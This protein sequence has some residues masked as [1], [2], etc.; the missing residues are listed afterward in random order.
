VRGIDA[1]RRD[2]TPFV[3]EAQMHLLEMLAREEQPEAALPAAISFLQ[4]RLR[5]LRRAT[6]SWLSFSSGSGWGARWKLTARPPRLP[7]L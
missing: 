7:G 4:G 6:S 3:A 2:S 5:A 1:R